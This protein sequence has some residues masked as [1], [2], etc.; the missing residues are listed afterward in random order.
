MFVESFYR[1]P[2]T[3][4]LI[5]PSTKTSRL[6]KILTEE[7]A[8]LFF[9]KNVTV[10]E[11]IDG[12]NLGISFQKD[13]EIRLQ[14]RGHCLTEPFL[15]QWV[16]LTRWLQC[17]I[18]C[19]FDILLDKYILFGEWCYAKHSIY[20]SC[21]PDWFIAFDLYDKESKRFLSVKKRN[22]IIAKSGLAIVPILFEGHFS[23]N[24]LNG[25][26]GKSAFGE[27]NREGLYFRIDSKDYLLYRAKYVQPCFTQSIDT[28]WSKKSLIH[29]QISSRNFKS[30]L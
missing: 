28:H 4:Y 12:A 9:T 22:S 25:F 18:E 3:P 6:D 5:K 20:Y 17:K 14:N 29:N 21:L 16:P 11:K 1:F 23:K 30:T 2:T 7:E 15:G 26:C 8:D 27:T 19:L 24:M 13:G 10:E